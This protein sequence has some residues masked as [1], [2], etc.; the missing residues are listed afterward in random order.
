VA[1]VRLGW[2]RQVSN[3]NLFRLSSLAVCR[4]HSSRRTGQRKATPRGPW[5]ISPASE[6]SRPDARLGCVPA[7]GPRPAPKPFLT[8]PGLRR[9]SAESQLPKGQNLSSQ[10]PT[11]QGA[12]LRGIRAEPSRLGRP[13]CLRSHAG[14]RRRVFHCRVRWPS[15]NRKCRF[16]LGG[17]QAKCWRI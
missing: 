15:R 1:L 6:Q 2:E 16:R 9:A 10:R 14:P 17:L 11:C 12:G 7:E 8:T 3:F 13:A 5:P 4:T